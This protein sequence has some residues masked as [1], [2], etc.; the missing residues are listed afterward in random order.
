MKTGTYQHHSVMLEN[1]PYRLTVQNMEIRSRVR[2]ED[3]GWS[4]ESGE[5]AEH[6]FNVAKAD[7]AAWIR[8]EADVG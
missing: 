5:R 8:D 7:P 3:F 6:E 4:E 2:E 1:G